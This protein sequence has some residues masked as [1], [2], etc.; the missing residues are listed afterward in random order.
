MDNKCGLPHFRNHS[1]ERIETFLFQLCLIEM[2]EEF[3]KVIRNRI[4]NENIQSNGDT[5]QIAKD[6][7]Q[8][9][10]EFMNDHISKYISDLRKVF[11]DEG[12]RIANSYTFDK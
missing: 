4:K 7:L 9:S 6:L 3:E 5:E 2:T 8:S 10:R 12:A 11:R 1:I